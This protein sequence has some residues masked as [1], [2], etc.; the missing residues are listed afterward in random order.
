MELDKET[1]EVIRRGEILADGVKGDFWSYVKGQLK[2]KIETLNSIDTTIFEGKSDAEL[3]REIRERAS[4]VKI[5]EDWVKE[6]EASA[7]QHTMNQNIINN[8]DHI[9]HV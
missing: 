3:A 9:L 1:R 5:L 7:S 2:N 4:V 8:E 6:I